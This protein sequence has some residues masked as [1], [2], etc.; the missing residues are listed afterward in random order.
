MEKQIEYKINRFKRKLYK[1]LKWIF[2]IVYFSITASV[3]IYVF[4]YVFSLKGS[5]IYSA[6][7]TFTFFIV[8]DICCSLTEDCMYKIYMY[9][10]RRKENKRKE[11]EE[12]ERTKKEEIKKMEEVLVEGGNYNSEVE[13]A[14]RQYKEFKKYIESIKE[15]LPQN[16]SNNMKQIFEKMQDIIN[17]LKEDSE[18]YYPIRHMFKAYFPEFARITH[19]YVDIITTEMDQ[20]DIQNFLKLVIEFKEYLDS[21]IKRIQDTDK[22]S[23][24]VG[25]KA[26]TKIIQAERKNGDKYAEK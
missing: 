16:I 5:I 23:F 15:K 9:G 25:L 6:A 26:L 21:I 22:E 12:L 1:L 11:K 18:Q 2:N 13:Y 24:D 8:M 17:I 4:Y 19:K 7:L 14:E 3:P 10:K 20:D